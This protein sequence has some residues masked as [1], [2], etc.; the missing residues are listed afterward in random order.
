MAAFRRFPAV[1]RRPRG[2]VN[3]G[4]EH[5]AGPVGRVVGQAVFA[6]LRRAEQGGDVARAQRMD[7]MLRQSKEDRDAP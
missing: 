5:I 6:A 2:S 1:H 4:F 7:T 3:G